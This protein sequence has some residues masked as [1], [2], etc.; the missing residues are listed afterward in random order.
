MYVTTLENKTKT[1]A[2]TPYQPEGKKKLLFPFNLRKQEREERKGSIEIGKT[3]SLVFS[4][5]KE[6]IS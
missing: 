3:T 4:S 6:K 5:I 1:A 2:F